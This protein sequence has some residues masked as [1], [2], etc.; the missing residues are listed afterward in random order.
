[1]TL[2]DV[3]LFGLLAELFGLFAVTGE[4][5][6]RATVSPFRKRH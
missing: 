6:R 5:M 4:A 3:L 2:Y 1:M